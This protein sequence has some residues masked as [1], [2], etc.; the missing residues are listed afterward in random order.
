M[1]AFIKIMAVSAL[2]VGLLEG[3]AASRDAMPA[4]HEPP[5]DEDARSSPARGDSDSPDAEPRQ[6]EEERLQVDDKPTLDARQLDDA[7]QPNDTKP[8]DA[9]VEQPKAQEPKEAA[10]DAAKDGASVGPRQPEPA[11]DPGP[12]P[13]MKTPASQ[14][15]APSLPQHEPT[16]TAPP[17]DVGAAEVTV[18]EGR[19]V[20]EGDVFVEE[21]G[22]ESPHGRVQALERAIAG[23]REDFGVEAPTERGGLSCEEIEDLKEGICGSSQKICKIAQ[24]YPQE[25]WFAERCQWSQRQCEEAQGRSERCGR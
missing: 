2:A 22:A 8:L 9:L 6:A 12:T 16:Q 15:Q 10:P 11:K 23:Y 3:C 24:E 5:S 25:A 21:E 4:R 20:L 7:K 19:G 1:R 17:V 13:H 18:G 14:D